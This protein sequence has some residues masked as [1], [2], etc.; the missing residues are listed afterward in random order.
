MRKFYVENEINQRFSL[1]GNRVYMIDPSGLGIK[2]ENSYIRIGD[3]FLRS[4]MNIGQSEIGGTIEFL[5][6]GAN[7]RFKEFYDF[8]SAASELYLVYDPGDGTEYIRDIDIGEVGK[9]ERT[10][11]TLPIT[12]DFICRSLYYLRNNN[13]F[14]MEPAT[15][16]KRYDYRYDFQYGDYGTYERM[17]D[18]NGHVEAPFECNI[19]GY[20][21]DPS[22]RIEKDGKTIYEVLFPITLEDGEYIRYSS[23]DGMLE[24]TYVSGSNETNLMHLLDITKD[25][26]FKLPRGSSK[27]IFS[28]ASDSA[29][30]ITATIYKMFEVV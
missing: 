2:R 13:R 12:V 8:C 26:F 30:M 19:Y 29:N 4:K 23:R 20:C 15:N 6:P 18:N 24:A 27:I 22:I 14:I 11:A 25:N 3:Y 9:N 28:S 1:W 5:D 10:G 21:V 17:I 16:E 7:K